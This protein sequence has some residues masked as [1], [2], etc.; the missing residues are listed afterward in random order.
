MVYTSKLISGQL[1]FDNQFNYTTAIL[2][3]DLYSSV[4]LSCFFSLSSGTVGRLCMSVD[5]VA[6]HCHLFVLALFWHVNVS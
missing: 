5:L 2:K 3:N 1:I 6:S 4:A